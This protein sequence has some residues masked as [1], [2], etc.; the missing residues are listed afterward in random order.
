MGL[1]T[2][3]LRETPAVRKSRSSKLRLLVATVTLLALVLLLQWQ[4]V[5]FALGRCLIDS[6]TP[7]PADLILVLGGDFSG[8]RVTVGAHLG[9]IGYAPTVLISSPPHGGRP[10]GELSVELLVKRGYRKEMFAVFPHAAAST[11]AEAIVLRGELE[12]RGVKR[13]ILVTTAYH[14][15]RAAI[16]FRLFCPGV[17]FISVPAADRYFTTKGWWEDEIS[18]EVFFSEW[19]KIFGSVAVAYPRYLLSRALIA[20]PLSVPPQ[21]GR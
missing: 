19:V 3:E 8:P 15:R 5:L 1:S 10:E 13:A 7:Q 18:R 6:E 4:A 2:G 20:A 17:H 14:S 9:E 21:A 12:R 11:I 16:V